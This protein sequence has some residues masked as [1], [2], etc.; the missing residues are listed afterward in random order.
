MSN[1]AA[2]LTDQFNEL[3]EEYTVGEEG[4]FAVVDFDSWSTDDLRR[5]QELVIQVLTIRASEYMEEGL[6]VPD[7]DEYDLTEEYAKMVAE[8][9]GDGFYSPFDNE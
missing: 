5:V 4:S 6:P 8:E 2:D 7:I 1:D 3:L 9:G